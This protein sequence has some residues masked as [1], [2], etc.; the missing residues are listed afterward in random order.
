M[1]SSQ[2]SEKNSIIITEKPDWISYDD[3]HELLYRAHESNREKGIFMFTSTLNGK[4][5]E[6]RIGDRGKCFVALY[7]DKLVGTNSY[8]ILTRNRWYRK[9]ELADSILIGVLPEYKNMGISSRLHEA[10]VEDVRQNGLSVLE[11]DT[12]EKNKLMREISLRRGFR[13][14]SSFASPNVKHYSVV[15][16]NWLDGCPFP[17]WYCTMRYCLQRFKVHLRYKPGHIKRF[18]I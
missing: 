12:A 18:G 14:V 15:M 7:G 16:V 13:Y 2:L 9:G 10:I 11:L 5:L 1:T 4:E 3:I 17:A 6:E 8:R